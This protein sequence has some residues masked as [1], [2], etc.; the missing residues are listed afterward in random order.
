MGSAD[1]RHNHRATQ[2][3]DPLAGH[4]TDKVLIDEDGDVLVLDF[5]GGNTVGWVDRDTYGTME[6]KLQRLSKVMAVLGWTPPRTT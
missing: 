4:Q 5:G 2:P 3:G 6:G 1:P